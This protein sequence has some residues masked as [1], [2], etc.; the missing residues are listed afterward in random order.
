MTS[1]QI[2]ALTQQSLKR[3]LAQVACMRK[4]GFPDIPDPTAQGAMEIPPGIDTN[5]PLFQAA[6][7]RCSFPG[8]GS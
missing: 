5:S 7:K 2:Q 3:K 4:H 8:G 6:Q 1:A